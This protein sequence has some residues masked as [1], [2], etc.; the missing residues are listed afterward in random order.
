MILSFRS[1][2]VFGDQVTHT[3]PCPSC[4]PHHTEVASGSLPHLLHVQAAVL[5]WLCAEKVLVP[6]AGT[7][8]LLLDDKLQPLRTLLT[9]PTKRHGDC[10]AC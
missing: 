8:P 10:L 2:V 1:F 3:F 6:P 4:D 7:Q 9:F 5:L